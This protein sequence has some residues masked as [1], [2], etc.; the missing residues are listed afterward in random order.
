MFGRNTRLT[1]SRGVFCQCLPRE[2]SWDESTP[3]PNEWSSSIDHPSTRRHTSEAHSRMATFLY[4]SDKSTVRQHLEGRVWTLLHWQG[5]R[6]IGF[7][8]F[9]NLG[10]PCVV[11]ESLFPHYYTFNAED[12][13]FFLDMLV[14]SHHE[15][16]T[17]WYKH[18]IVRIQCHNLIDCIHSMKKKEEENHV[19]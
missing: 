9:E 6:V 11:E 13:R 10:V 17:E 15:I 8:V 3:T 5:L 4:P 2:E 12:V 1:P 16:S 14:S 19:W 7:L 18:L